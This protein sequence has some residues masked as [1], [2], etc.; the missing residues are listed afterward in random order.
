MKAI[1]IRHGNMQ[2][3]IAK[4]FILP[5]D[6]SCKISILGQKGKGVFMKKLMALVLIG[7]MAVTC[8]A[9]CGKA[10]TGYTSENTEF[11]IGGTGPLTGDASSYGISVQK[12]AELAIKQINEAGGL[13]DKT[14]K[15][16]M[17][18]DKA[19]AADA[20]TGYDS[21]FESGLF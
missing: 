4:K 19:T 12:G 15:L 2:S 7:V 20:A 9:G 11:I 21:L 13:N 3:Q 18:D 10:N 8:L 5:I 16:V 17:K 14:F 6:K 1:F